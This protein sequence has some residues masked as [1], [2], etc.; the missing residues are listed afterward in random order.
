MKICK[1]CQSCSSPLEYVE[2]GRNADGTINNDYCI[3][4]YDNGK[5]LDDRTLEEEIEF[6]IPLYIDNRD[7]SEDEA[8]NDLTKLLSNLKRWTKQEK[9]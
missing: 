8:R 2:N 1:I 9:I 4:C 7:I 5:F 6:L 3:F